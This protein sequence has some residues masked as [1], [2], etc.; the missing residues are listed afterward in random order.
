[1]LSQT[2][3]PTRFDLFPCYESASPRSHQAEFE[4][5]D[6]QTTR[7]NDYYNI[8]LVHAVPTNED[9]VDRPQVIR[10]FSL[11]KFSTKL[12]DSQVAPD[13]SSAMCRCTSAYT[14]TE[15]SCSFSKLAL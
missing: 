7:E 1:M 5:V 15:Y 6:P 2:N 13:T 14:F 12:T 9:F 11:S 10:T 8:L 4:Y 3:Y